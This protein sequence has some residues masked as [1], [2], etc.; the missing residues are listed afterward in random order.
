MRKGIVILCAIV[1]FSV[2][3]LSGCYT[4]ANYPE[5]REITSQCVEQY[6]KELL[7]SYDL[8]K[9]NN[10]SGISRSANQNK[11][12]GIEIS[13]NSN[14]YFVATPDGNRRIQQKANTGRHAFMLTTL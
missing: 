12:K 6:E 7:G 2:L 1:C 14:Q 13:I 5:I 11:D 3:A 10:I 4:S 8:C 9:N